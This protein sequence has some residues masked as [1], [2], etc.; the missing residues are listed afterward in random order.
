MQPWFVTRKK[1]LWGLLLVAALGALIFSL[2]PAPIPVTAVRVTGAPFV[3]WVSEE[4]RTRLRDSFTISAP[5][6]GFLQRVE[7]EV[8]DPVEV[9][10]V[11]FRLEPLPAP[12]L[13]ARSLEQ[14]RE[15]L[16]ASLAR[17]ESARAV[18]ETER[19]EASFSEAELKR[20]QQLRQQDLVSV[21]E[22]E[23]VLSIH[24][25][26]QAAARA[27][28]HAVEVARFEVA[29]ARAVLNIA[30]GQRPDPEQ[31]V[32]PVRSPIAG[33]V[34]QRQRCCE[35]AIQSGD[36]VL[37]VG[38]LAMLEVQV[39][40]LSMD[41]V[42]VRPGMRVKMD[43]WGGQDVLEGRVRRVEPTGFTRVSAL[44]VEEQRV[45]VIVDFDQV[46]L[47][48]EQLGVG[49]RVEAAFVLWE[50]VHALQVPTSALFRVA[51]QWTVFVVEQDRA[52]FRP[53]EPGRR[54]GMMTQIIAGL[55]SGE[56]VL[57][58]PGDRVADG[59]RVLVTH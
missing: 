17:L 13:D 12:A 26:N 48:T 49:Y 52:C 43:G 34:L 22:M 30:S 35:G 53:V 46:D 57:T 14:A 39:D 20:Y 54:S 9:G 47:A 33:L 27:A 7:I 29:S 4:G 59:A 5:I 23:R 37:E 1:W 10:Q 45:P 55:E 31:F 50:T 42:R 56:T 2:L 6:S 16:S 41:A 3:E 32:L 18:L 11:L 44:G 58:H 38:D 36:V 51:D 21:N 15:H 25:R 28:E 40:L 8:G 24:K 19:A